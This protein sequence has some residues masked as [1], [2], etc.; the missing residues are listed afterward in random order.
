MGRKVLLCFALLLL[1]SSATLLTM[2]GCGGSKPFSKIQH[3]V[4]VFQENRTPDNL[5]QDPV[6][7]RAGADI[8]SSGLNSFGS[9]VQLTRIPLKIHYDIG[10][11]HFSFLR[12]YN[13]GKM[14][15][16]NRIPVGCIG[17]KNCA[18][19]NPQYAY[20]DPA[21]VQ[22]YF[23]MAEQYTFGDRMFQTNQGPSFPAHQFIMS[24]TSAPNTG[25]F[26]VAENPTGVSDA[27]HDAGCISPPAEYVSVVGPNGQESTGMYPCTDHPTLTDEL[28]A[29]G[30]T[31][32]YY[33]PSAGVIWTAPTAIRHICGPNAPPPNATACIGPDWVNHVVLYTPEHPAPILTDIANGQLPAVSWVM[34]AGQ[35]SDHPGTPHSSGGP[36]WVAAIVNAI[37]NSSYWENTAI[38]VTRDDWGGWYDHVPPPK[39]VDDGTSWG[40]GYV[41]GFRVPLIVISPYARA[42]Y[43]SHVNHDFGS[44]LKFVEK[45]FFLP[46]LGYADAHADDIADCFNFNQSPLEFRTINAPLTAEHFLN[47]KTLPLDPDDD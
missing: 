1:A 17:T 9:R 19:P 37:G 18:P 7:I 8:A 33:T 10:H 13:G 45:L 46:S 15:G 2:N 39:I 32:R 12:S 6:L 25:S 41:Y 35:N 42:G 22:P 40:S 14:N 11:G 4:I 38:V 29:T 20:V 23:Q 31:W 43:I 28:N 47:D 21:D 5:F 27:F 36:S 34:L 30:I 44:I 3:V 24:G 16:A 26:F